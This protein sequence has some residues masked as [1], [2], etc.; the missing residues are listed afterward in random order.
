MSTPPETKLT[1][2]ICTR[3]QARLLER[4][5][6]AIA[7]QRVPPELGWEVVVVENQCSDDTVQV[8]HRWQ[9]EPR[10]PTLRL[11]SE[12]RLGAGHARK[13]GM[14]HST[15]ELIAFVDDDCLLADDW[16]AQACEFAGEHPDAGVFGGRNE[17]VWETPPSA[18]CVDYGESLARQD[19]GEAPHRLPDEGRTVLCGAGLVL[20]RSALLKSGYLDTGLLTGPSQMIRVSERS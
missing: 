5:L 18:L 14:K 16:I 4:T 1:V 13:T 3:N 20:R 8:V 2:L 12:P 7:Q 6:D 15:G 9:R 11:L 19:L 10:I 17:L